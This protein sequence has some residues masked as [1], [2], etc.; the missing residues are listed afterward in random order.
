M[1]VRRDRARGLAER[2]F[3]RNPGVTKGARHG[4]KEAGDCIEDW[5][6]FS[7]CELVFLPPPMR[8]VLYRTAAT[9]QYLGNNAAVEIGKYSHK[10]KGP[11]EGR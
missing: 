1:R 3:S 10:L 9:V 2:L 8:R 11:C 6:W 7:R 5:Q 4:S